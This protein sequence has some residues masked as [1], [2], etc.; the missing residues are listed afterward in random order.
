MTNFAPADHRQLSTDEHDHTTLGTVLTAFAII[1]VVTFAL[2]I[3]Y[4]GHLYEDD[5]LWVT[6]AEEMLRG[7]A[8]YSGIYFDKPPALPLVYAGL[9]KIFGTHILIIRLFTIAY[10]VAVSA[11]L[12]KFGS[13]LYDK[14]AGLIAAAMFAFF[15]TTAAS[16]HTQGFDTDFL[17]IL[18]YTA[19]AYLLTRGGLEKRTWLSVAGGAVAGLA[20]QVN[21]KGVFDLVFFALLLFAVWFR[22]YYAR[23]AASQVWGNAGR[24][25]LISV[26]RLL[27]LSLAGFVIGSLPFILYLAATHSLSPY[28]LYVWV[29]GF[30]Y[31]NY[32]SLLSIVALG[33][34]VNVGYFALNSTLLITVVFVVVNTIKRA[35]QLTR[36]RESEKG[37][38]IN[39]RAPEMAV[40]RVFMSDVTLLIWLAVSYAG[41]S[42]GGRFYTHY[43]FQIMPALSLIGARGLSEIAAYGRAH[44]KRLQWALA[45][46]LVIGFAIA[47]IR[48]HTRTITLAADWA[49]GKKSEATAKWFHERLNREERQVAALVR[50]LPEPA[51][52]ADQI[53]LEGIRAEGPRTRAVDGPADYLFVWGYRPELYYWSGLLPASRYLSAQPLTGVPAD[54]QYVNGEHRSILADS[55]TASAR[56]QLVRDL[57]ETRP[58]YIVDELGFFNLELAILK[59]DDLH[60]VMDNYKPLGATG[61]FLV[62]IRKDLTKKQLLRQQAMPR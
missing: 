41:V 48:F 49:R 6:A 56:E 43:F 34:R 38:V 36:N 53:G 23:A 51:D 26:L 60:G 29:W 54:A 14:R 44:G 7:K 52:A 55:V 45:A 57:N 35:R 32:N 3:F 42:V 16:G 17:M 11:V 13:W 8:L 5:G 18:P 59:Y 62:Y 33:L 24:V 9:F 30:R 21:P 40:R 50:G 12:Y 47:V 27:V 25:R 46:L 15:S 19:S 10:S 22:P 37:E 4:A 39:S 2:R 28:W 1:A 20:V 58:K 61:T 31:A